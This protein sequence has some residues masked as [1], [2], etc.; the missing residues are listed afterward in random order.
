EELLFIILNSYMDDLL[1]GIAGIDDAEGDPGTKLR[2]FIQFHVHLYSG[3]IHRSKLIIQ[4]GHCL[5]G[6]WR[7]TVKDK[8]KAY[9]EY[10]KRAFSAYCEHQGQK[11]DHPSAHVMI[12]LGICNWIYKWYDPKGSLTPDQLAE[13]IFR[14]F[15]NGY[16][17]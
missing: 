7:Q 11:L 15:F 3:D 13:L 4:D 10:W 14:R 16:P 12:L 5:S 8:E 2:R 6:E 1:A 17:G 9:T